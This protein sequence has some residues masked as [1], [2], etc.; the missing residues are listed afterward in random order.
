MIR[1]YA[2]LGLIVVCYIVYQIRKI[3]KP[4]VVEHDKLF[5]QQIKATALDTDVDVVIME[6]DN[7][8]LEN[9]ITKLKE[10]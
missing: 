6:Q 8:K 4:I 2:I 1:L 3:F 10:S 7:E 5:D 9:E